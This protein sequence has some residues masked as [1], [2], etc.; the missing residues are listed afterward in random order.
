MRPLPTPFQMKQFKPT[1]HS[2]KNTPETSSPSSTTTR[3]EVDVLARELTERIS[4]NPKKAAR[5]F[6]NWLNGRPKEK[7]RKKAA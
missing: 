6:E 5:I 2:R 4:K 7:G 1:Q 3:Q